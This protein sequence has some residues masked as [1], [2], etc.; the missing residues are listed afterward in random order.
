MQCNAM[1]TRN[2]W[3]KANITTT[4]T[5]L[6]DDTNEQ[7]FEMKRKKASRDKIAHSTFAVHIVH[8]DA[9]NVEIMKEISNKMISIV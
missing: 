4:E 3:Q 9:D 7:E 1:H 6:N 2:R 8:V 5:S